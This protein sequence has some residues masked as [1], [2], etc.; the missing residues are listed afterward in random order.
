MLRK[1]NINEALEFYHIDHKYK[2]I[3]YEAIDQI[4]H[5]SNML[6]D[7]EK[8]YHRLY[9]ENFNRV[10]SLWDIKSI[11]ELFPLFINPFITN[12][13]ILY[14]YQVHKNT[15]KKLKL[16]EEQVVIHKYRV[17]ECFESDL[18]NRNYA[19]VRL[20]QLLW[21]IYF[22]RGK[23]IEVGSLQY[24]YEDEKNIKIHIPKKTDFDI[25]GVKE[26]LNNSKIEI[27]KVFKITDY[28]YRCNSWLL[29]KRLNEIIEK[30]TNIS[31]FF[32]LFDVTDG[33]DCIDDIL[34]FV[35]GLE[36][37][38]HYVD[39]A[40]NTKLQR[41]IKKALINQEKFYLGQGVLKEW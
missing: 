6:E 36:K 41:A 9:H 8:L 15:I 13:F 12:L 23:I 1:E 34:N 38:D 35:W 25:Q 5:S 27:K 40:E 22:I 31:N 14:G 29:S 17:K 2:D 30:N 16:S 18:V 24:E 33:D 21:A 10:T 32:E 19:G 37:C 7:F 20:S 26:S 3:C 11:N 28:K 4:N 39:L